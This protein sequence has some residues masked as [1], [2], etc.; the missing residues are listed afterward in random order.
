VDVAHGKGQFS[1]AYPN[2]EILFGRCGLGEEN[3]QT[4]LILEILK[5]KK[6]SSL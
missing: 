6:V 4:M 5:G 2:G 1:G 3:L